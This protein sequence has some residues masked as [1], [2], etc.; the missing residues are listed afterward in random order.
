MARNAALPILTAEPGLTHYLEEIRRFPML[1]RQEEYMLAKRWR[2]HRDRDAANRLVTSHLRLVTKIARDYHRYGLPISEAISAG[3]VGLMQAVARF[4][5]EKGFRLATYAVWWIR[6]SIQEYILRSWSL[7]KMATTANHKKLF[8]NLRKAQ[9]KISIL[10]DGDMRLDQVQIIAQRFGVSETDVIY[11]N[12]R[13]GGD[14]SLNAAIREDGTSGE[15]QDWLVDESPDQETT[16][17]AS[18]ELD[19]RRKALSDALTVLNERERRI[20]ETRRLAD[21]QIT[22]AELAE[23]FGVTRERVR[24]IEV[25]AFEKVQNSVKHRVVMMETPALQ[26]VG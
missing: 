26:Q 4:Q 10:D 16:L 22:R 9:R 24:Q 19:N 8:F 14:A 3:N 1:E 6:A 11:M 5:P 12:R 23:E 18:E 20:F 13:L 7:V 17:A 25:R 15:W 2:E 21:E